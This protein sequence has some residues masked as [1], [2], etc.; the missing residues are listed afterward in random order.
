MCGGE[1]ERKKKK[2]HVDE[3]KINNNKLKLS[4]ANITFS[5]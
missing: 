3:N 1:K 5:Q 4:N 2:K